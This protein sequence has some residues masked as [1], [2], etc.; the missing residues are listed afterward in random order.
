MKEQN[1]NTLPSLSKDLN[2]GL[3]RQGDNYISGTGFEYFGGVRD[4]EGLKITE[5]ICRGTG[6]EFLVSIRVFDAKGVLIIDIPV[7]NGVRYSREIV[8]NYV[9]DGLMDMMKQGARK[10]G[11]ELPIHKVK[12]RLDQKLKLAYYSQSYD[13]V[14]AWAKEVELI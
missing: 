13:A 9:L 7:N 4:F 10:Q 6:V 2:T 8:R 12:T 5:I 1:A 3:I 14:L 11:V